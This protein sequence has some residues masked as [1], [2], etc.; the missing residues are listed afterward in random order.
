M[1][2]LKSL[3]N[4]FSKL[5]PEEVEALE[6]YRSSIDYLS[7]KGWNLEFTNKDNNH[8][9]LVMAKLFSAAKGSI[10]VF[11]GS[12]SGEV[13]NNPIYKRELEKSILN[14]NKKVE[15]VFEN[16]P[17]E[18]SHCL[19]MLRELKRQGNEVKMYLLNRTYQ[20][21]VIVP[22]SL[23]HFTIADDNMFRYETDKINFRAFCN[24]DDK[25]F[26]QTLNK[27][28]LILKVNSKELN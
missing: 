8:A 12:F 1:S 15:V 9:A 26:V 14:S 13:S 6:E 27:N 4:G 16:E 2:E 11:T 18:D 17:N 23:G 21:D 28:F 7:E 10:K 3:L 25:E 5:T 20:K 19:S 24:F 22:S